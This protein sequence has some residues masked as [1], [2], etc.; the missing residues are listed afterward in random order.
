LNPFVTRF[1]NQSWVVP[2]SGMCLVLGFMVS[3]AWVTKENRTSR[4]AFL[5]PDQR[6]RVNDSLVDFEA[7]EQTRSEVAK[8]QA[9]KTRLENALAK[10]GDDGKVLNQSLQEAKSLAGLTPVEGPGVVVTLSDS[11]KTETGF[12]GQTAVNPDAIVHDKDVLHTV[13]ELFASGAEAVAVNDLRVSPTSSFRCVG[14]TILVN[15]V[16]IATPVRVRAIGDPDT[17][18]GAMNMP[19]GSLAEIRLYDAA[20]VA[21]EK[22]KMQQLP[23]YTGTTGRRFAKVPKESSKETSE[24]SGKKEK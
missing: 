14:T 16:K 3:L 22:V 12:G 18:F 6:Q 2:V 21:I 17:L 1:N 10:N 24:D 4:S 20:M 8:L 11:M 15:D 13:N 19:G 7:F 9:E 5:P 23:A